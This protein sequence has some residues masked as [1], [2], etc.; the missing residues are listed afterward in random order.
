MKPLVE[1]NRLKKSWRCLKTMPKG[2]PANKWDKHKNFDLK[3]LKESSR[4]T[5]D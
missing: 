5:F 1:S 3:E 2:P 4:S